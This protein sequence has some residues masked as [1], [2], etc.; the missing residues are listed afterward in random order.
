MP[1]C[2]NTRITRV[3]IKN[4]ENGLE[5]ATFCHF[6]DY[7]IAHSEAKR[8]N[9]I[10][11]EFFFASP[12]G[13]SPHRHRNE[14]DNEQNCMFFACI[15]NQFPSPARHAPTHRMEN[16]PRLCA[17]RFSAFRID[18]FQLSH[19]AYVTIPETRI[20]SLGNDF[21]FRRACAC[22]PLRL[23]DERGRQKN[24]AKNQNDVR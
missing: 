8:K 19:S 17:I 11:T 5:W 18:V 12:V 14:D 15:E 23:A 22:A 21:L 7:F 3:K 2:Q 1:E 4:C 6:I 9:L 10:E 20:C 16:N 13:C 24:N